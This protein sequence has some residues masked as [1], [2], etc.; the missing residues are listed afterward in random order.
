MLPP[1]AKKNRLARLD[2]G[3]PVVIPII[4][5]VRGRV[6]T[7]YNDVPREPQGVCGRFFLWL[8]VLVVLSPAI[9]Q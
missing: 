6:T 8:V 1:A 5:A 2:R 7:M 9:L 4:H 3:Q